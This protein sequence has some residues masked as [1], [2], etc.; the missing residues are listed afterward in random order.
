MQHGPHRVARCASELRAASTHRTTRGR[1]RVRARVR[2]ATPTGREAAEDRAGRARGHEERDRVGGPGL[3][4][5]VRV[6]VR[7][8]GRRTP[9]TTSAGPYGRTVAAEPFNVLACSRVG[10]KPRS[11]SMPPE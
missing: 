1:A 9:R 11:S 8:A 6:R 10:K 4:V 5:R 3:R 7:L 2:A